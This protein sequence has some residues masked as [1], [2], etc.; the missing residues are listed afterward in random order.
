ME[1]QY[2][3]QEKRLLEVQTMLQIKK[4]E[5]REICRSLKELKQKIEE[6]DERIQ[7]EYEN[8]QWRYLQP[9]ENDYKQEE[10]ESSEIQSTS[11]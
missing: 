4:S 6:N 5:N 8:E 11:K 7:K 10:E 3:L 2:Q 1:K 9:P